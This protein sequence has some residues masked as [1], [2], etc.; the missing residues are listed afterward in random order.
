M[1][2]V[3]KAYRYGNTDEATK[4]A[5]WNKGKII[6]GRPPTEYRKDMCGK[7]IRYS[8]HGHETSYGWEI[9][10][11]FPKSRGGKDDLSNL[12][13]LYWRNNRA[14]SDTY[15]WHCENGYCNS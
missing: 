11:I 1:N 7:T 12:Q 6:P 13:P 4:R 15:P 5:V 14:K 3:T 8:A 2:I 10:H 9:D